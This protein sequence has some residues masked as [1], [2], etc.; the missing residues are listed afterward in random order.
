[1]SGAGNDF[2]VIDES[3]ARELGT[4]LIEW[5]RQVCRRGVSIGADGLLIVERLGSSRVGVR[6]LNPDGS[7]AFCGNGSRCAARYAAQRYGIEHGAEFVLQTCAGELPAVVKGCRVRLR[8]A[9]P[10]DRGE[11]VIKFEGVDYAARLI[12]AGTPHL[13]VRV[14]EPDDFPLD[15]LG[16]CFRA[17]QRFGAIGVNVSVWAADGSQIR[18]RTWEKGVEGETLACGSGAIAATM[19]ARIEHGGESFR[20]WP[21]SGIPIDVEFSASGTVCFEGEARRIFEGTLTDEASGE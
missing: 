4:E 12:D 8:L 3:V 2:I 10:I 16:P 18:L 6:F 7:E 19:T 21:R 1:M 5:T 13:M 15:R 11:V 9:A 20:V 17:D 14:D